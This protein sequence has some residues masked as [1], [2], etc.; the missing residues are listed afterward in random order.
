MAINAGSDVII[1]PRK[2]IRDTTLPE[3][4]PAASAPVFPIT[5]I[6]LIPQFL[7][8]AVVNA[9][10]RVRFVVPVVPDALKTLHPRLWI[11]AT[12]VPPVPA[13]GS[14]FVAAACTVFALAPCGSALTNIMPSISPCPTFS[15]RAASTSAA[16]SLTC[17]SVPSNVLQT[18]A[19]SHVYRL[20]LLSGPTV[21]RLPDASTYCTKAISISAAFVW[22][23]ISFI[24][25]AISLPPCLYKLPPLLPINAICFF[26]FSLLVVSC[27]YIT[28]YLY[29]TALC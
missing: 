15:A 20:A 14:F 3:T 8:R 12:P 28:L 24:I 19:P 23:R 10:A 22:A 13:I 11:S 16:F 18:A 25:P 6:Y 1:I 7:A 5:G 27:S 4:F 2:L 26:I 21:S 29:F 17:C 9:T